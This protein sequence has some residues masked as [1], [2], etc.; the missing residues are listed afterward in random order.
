MDSEG[1]LH[2]M[3]AV[4]LLEDPGTSENHSES[5]VSAHG[6]D[7]HAPRRRGVK[8]VLPNDKTTRKSNFKQKLFEGLGSASSLL[9]LTRNTFILLKERR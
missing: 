1:T 5:Q 2:P 8:L 7:E 9:L 4:V 3:F 6:G